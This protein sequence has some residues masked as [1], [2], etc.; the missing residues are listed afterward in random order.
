VAA[1]NRE[2]I[3]KVEPIV[4]LKAAKMLGVTFPLPLLGT[5]RQGNRM[6]TRLSVQ[7]SGNGPPL[8]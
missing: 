1:Q 6:N 8:P 5:G 7:E 4:N 3:T 2:Q